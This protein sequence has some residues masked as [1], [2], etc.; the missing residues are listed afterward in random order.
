VLAFVVFMPTSLWAQS[1]SLEVEMS[2]S[3]SEEVD[4]EKKDSLPDNLHVAVVAGIGNSNMYTSSDNQY[5]GK[6]PI[7]HYYVGGLVDYAP[8]RNSNLFIESGVMFQQKGYQS[9]NTGYQAVEESKMRMLCLNFPLL[10]CYSLDVSGIY[11]VPQIGPYFSAVLMANKKGFRKFISEVDGKSDIQKYDNDL[12][13]E[14]NVHG[15]NKYRRFDCG[16]HFGISI[17]FL[18]H[19]RGGIGYDLGFMNF[20]R[21]KYMDKKVKTNVG[22]FSVNFA[23][24]FF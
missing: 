11:V 2:Q 1:D 15:E 19:F 8:F 14:E 5:I 20:Q 13:E 9:E 12:F 21:E 16:L 23:Y 10:A 3:V 6:R 7:L 17:V 4:T 22:A 24:Y 18:K